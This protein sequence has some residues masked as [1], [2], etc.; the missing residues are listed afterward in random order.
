MPVTQTLLAVAF[1]AMVLMLALHALSASGHFPRQHRSP[2]LA[3]GLG[4][5]VLWGSIAVAAASLV[6]G[7]IAA[8]MLLPWYAAV[9][10]AGMAILIAP[11]I[12]QNFPDAF[13]DG[14]VPLIV[15][16][17]AGAVLALVLA[18]AGLHAAT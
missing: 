3:A 16:A 18:C 6:A 12:L 9:I 13:V 7:L 1:A 5:A 17:A 10:G 15:F 11:L 2:A 14:V 8:L 4:R